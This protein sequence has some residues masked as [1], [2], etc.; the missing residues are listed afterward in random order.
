MNAKK[1]DYRYWKGLA[2]AKLGRKAEAEALF[3]A[4]VSDGGGG[5]VRSHVN[6]YG[7]EGTTGETVEQIN[8]RAHYTKGLGELGLGMAGAAKA[9]FAESDRLVPNRL[10]TREML[11]ACGR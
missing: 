3:R 10:W 11:G 6:F 9:S 5:I 2:L 4:L 7:A 1:T 8:A